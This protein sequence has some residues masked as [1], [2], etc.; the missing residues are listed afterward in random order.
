MKIIPAIDIHDKEAVRLLKGD[1][2]QKTVYSSEPWELVKAFHRMGASVIHIVDLNAARNGNDNINRDCILKIRNSCDAKIQLG[3]GIRNI[4]KLKFY[5]SIGINRFILGTAAVRNPEIIDEALR[6][7]GDDRIVVS[8]DARDNF[9]R[10]S[11]WEEDSKIHYEE[12]LTKLQ[13]QGVKRIVYTDISQD[14]MLQ[15]PSLGSYKTILEKFNFRLIASGGISCIKDILDLYNIPC[16]N[17]IYGVITGKAIYEGK[18]DLRE[19]LDNTNEQS[20]G[21]S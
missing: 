20:N 18:L 5:D 1:Y 11:G 17:K 13:S 2:S 14:G 7:M 6:L 8:V 3:G 15:G 21:S 4:E 10:I 19:A 16:K 9:V 12:L